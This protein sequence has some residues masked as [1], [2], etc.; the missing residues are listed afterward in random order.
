MN[1]QKRD[2]RPNRRRDVPGGLWMRCTGC[3][4]MIYRNLVVERGNVCP[5]CSY[6]F[7]ITSEE[8]I[9]LLC[10][11]ETFRE[12]FSELAPA[13]PLNFSARRT[14]R[15]RLDET[16]KKT[17]LRDACVVGCAE[18]GEVP[19]VFGVSDSRFLMGSMGSV[20]GEKIARGIEMAREQGRPFIFVSGSGGGARMDE[21]MFSLMQMAKT[22]AAIQRLH[23][24]GGLFVSILTN[25]TM[26]GAMAS[27]AALGDVIIAEPKALIGFAGP[28][29]IK[30]TINADLPANF[31]SSEFNL[32]HG[33]ID[34]V[35][36]RQEL[37]GTLIRILAYFCQEA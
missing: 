1:E 36:D 30:Q 14:Y 24:A 25:P 9:R 29:V 8:R 2:P 32:E 26:G 18:I 37:R 23:E 6:H 34:R 22:S 11:P 21:G 10:D 5:E 27:F 33:F 4:K 13:D 12:E 17:G 31:Q 3:S 28:N 7:P 20:V 15:E 35:V 16:Q 19:V